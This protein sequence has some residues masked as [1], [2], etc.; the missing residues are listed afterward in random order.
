M[1]ISPDLKNSHKSGQCLKVLRPGPC[2][3]GVGP[4]SKKFVSLIPVCL[5]LRADYSENLP[6]DSQVNIFHKTVRGQPK[7]RTAGILHLHHNRG[8]N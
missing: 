1:I 5:F 4:S 8:S 3:A 7:L 2:S 6:Q